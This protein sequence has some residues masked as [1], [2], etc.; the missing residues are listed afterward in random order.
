MFQPV[1]RFAKC[2]GQVHDYVHVDMCGFMRDELTSLI[3]CHPLSTS[4]TYTYVQIHK[5][6]STTAEYN[7]LP[8]NGV[9]GTHV[10][11]MPSPS[12]SPRPY[13]LKGA[14]VRFVIN[15]EISLLPI[16][17]PIITSCT[18]EALRP[19]CITVHCWNSISHRLQVLMTFLFYT[20][21][22]NLINKIIHSSE[23]IQ[24]LLPNEAL[25]C[26][27][28]HRIKW[29]L[30]LGHASFAKTTWCWHKHIFPLSWYLPNQCW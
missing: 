5:P 23:Q 22:N 14:Y 15:V 25:F 21:I 29:F 20:Y 11:S 18:Y 1:K 7:I 6:S 9:N 17:W 30:P 2:C 27:R 16:R 28:C 8:I 12:T 26:R 24:D 4:C 3:V 19:V 10:R 13:M